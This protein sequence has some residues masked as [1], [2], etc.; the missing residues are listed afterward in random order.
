VDALRDAFQREYTA[1][2]GYASDEDLELVN[3]R[4]LATGVR[5]H[6]LDFRAVRVV[7]DRPAPPRRRAVHFTRGAPPVDTPVVGREAVA[8]E[9]TRG[10]LIV[11]SYDSTVAVPPDA[12]I[13]R[14]AFG[15]L[16]LARSPA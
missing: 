10:P 12:W 5:E 6:R 15:N 11:E 14:D 1:T 8:A 4:C 13:G 2:Y 7:A 16:V 9:P 3:V